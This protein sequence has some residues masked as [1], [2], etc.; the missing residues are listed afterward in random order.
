MPAIVIQNEELFPIT[1][2]WANAL[3]VKGDVILFLSEKYIKRHNLIGPCIN[4]VVQG[5]VFPLIDGLVMAAKIDNDRDGIEVVQKLFRNRI[6]F[7]S[8]VNTG[9]VLLFN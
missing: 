7:K 8:D 2:Q 1:F 6:F 4:A 9:D 5:D 3:K